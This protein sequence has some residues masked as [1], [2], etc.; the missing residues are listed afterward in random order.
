MR[1][2]IKLLLILGL[3]VCFPNLTYSQFQTNNSDSIY[4]QITNRNSIVW[5]LTNEEKIPHKDNI[6][7]SGKNVSTIIYYEIDEDKNLS[8]KKDIIFPQ[9]RT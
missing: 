9:L 7:M 3:S 1:E 6:E 5:D 2:C 4:W 8:L